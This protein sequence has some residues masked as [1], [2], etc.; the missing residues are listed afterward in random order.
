MLPILQD[1]TD[2]FKTRFSLLKYE[3]IDKATAIIADLIVDLVIIFFLAISFLFFL[4]TLGFFLSEQLRSDLAGFAIVTFLCILIVVFGHLLK[5][6][7]QNN[8]VRVFIRKTF[9]KR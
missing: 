3:S 8:L 4:V 7:F 1:L 6:P 2:Y 9:K 5:I